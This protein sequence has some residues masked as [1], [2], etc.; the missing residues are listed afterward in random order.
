MQWVKP[1]TEMVTMDKPGVLLEPSWLILN[2]TNY[3]IG[4]T[5]FKI[6]DP[7]YEPPDIFIGILP[8][9]RDLV[10]RTSLNDTYEKASTLHASK[11][12]K[13][14]MQMLQICLI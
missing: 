12:R 3:V 2:S 6:L 11:M 4:D 9:I 14:I 13:N 8:R 10:F 1:R 5:S 7:I